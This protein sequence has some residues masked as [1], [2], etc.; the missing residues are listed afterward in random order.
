MR[1]VLNGAIIALALTGAA[2]ATAGTAS[3]ERVGVSLNFG[4]VAFGYQDGYW[5]RGHRWHHW[6]DAD[7][8]R[9]Y[10]LVTTNHYYGWRHD[11]DRDHGWHDRS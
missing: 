9:R 7:E 5:D 2:L 8:V 1:K 3:A 11:R 10:R 4:N 6:R